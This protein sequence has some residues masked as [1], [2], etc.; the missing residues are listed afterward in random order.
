MQS[1]PERMGSVF[2]K[3]AKSRIFVL[4]SSAAFSQ[5]LLILF[6][7]VLT[8]MYDPDA[9]GVMA[10]FLS[11]VNVFGLVFAGRYEQALYLVKTR[12]DK[13]NLVAVCTIFITINCVI[14]TV[15]LTLIEVFGFKH[16]PTPINSLLPLGLASYS[17]I[18][19]LTIFNISDDKS[20]TIATARIFQ[21]IVVILS[22]IMLFKFAGTG[23]IYS[24]LIGQLVNLYL[25]RPSNFTH[26]KFKIDHEKSLKIAKL[27]IHF[28]LYNAPSTLLNGITLNALPIMIFQLHGAT[29]AG[30]Y[31]LVQRT[32]G[33]PMGVLGVAISQNYA[34]EF[35]RVDTENDRLE[36][37]IRTVKK[38]IPIAI[39]VLLLSISTVF[40]FPIIFGEEWR[41]AGVYAA[42]LAPA[43]SLQMLIS[44]ISQ[45][46]VLLQRNRSQL[47]IDCIRLTLF[48]LCVLFTRNLSDRY[49]I[50]SISIVQSLSYIIIFIVCLKMIKSS[51]KYKT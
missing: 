42:L 15:I 37:L 49:L 6:S 11:I 44:P 31:A 21:S 40:L 20:R 10:L 19:L 17:L 35:G 14:A 24:L 5:I 12:T 47:A 50:T 48:A 25:L 45:T 9:F 30:L 8:R 29:A 43:A 51:N 27:Y 16:I 7:P 26:L 32:I 38:N 23:L 4:S 41:S 13:F 33:L 18:Q 46:P 39:L 3:L 36:I 22:Q 34:Y 28:P 1:L 2:K